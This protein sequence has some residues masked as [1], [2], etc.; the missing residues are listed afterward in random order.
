MTF[1]E[2]IRSDAPLS[3]KLGCKRSIALRMSYSTK[4]G[5]P[6]TTHHY[7]PQDKTQSASRFTVFIRESNKQ[8]NRMDES[9]K[10]SMLVF[11]SHNITIV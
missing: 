8:K 3:P 2:Y 11:Y 10:E 7:P 1:R 4:I 5:L 9:K 6:I